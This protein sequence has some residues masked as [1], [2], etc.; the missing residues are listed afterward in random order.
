MM[1]DW[2]ARL[3]DPFVK[4]P[5]QRPPDRM[6][7]FARFFLAPTKGLLAAIIIVSFLSAVAEMALL[8]FLGIVV[9]WATVTPPAEFFSR[10]GWALAGMA[11]VILVVRPATTLLSRGLTSIAFVPGLTALVRWQSYR[12]VLR[13]SLTF[14]QNDFAGRVA[15]KVL[16]SG[17]ALR[18][19]VVN[20]I[21]GI[22][23]LVVY[24][25]GTIALFAGLDP[26]LIIP[27]VLW[28]VAY[29]ATIYFM[30]PPV[31]SKSEVAAEANS[32]LS[33][34]VVDSYT[35]IQT[36]KLFASSSR[37]EAF[38]RDGMQYHTDRFHEM[39]R[40]LSA[41]VIW[42]W[43][44]NGL[45]IGGTAAL[46]VWLWMDGL[47]TVGAL[48]LATG[49]ALRV[50]NMSGWI[51]WTI[52]NIFENVGTVQEGMETIA[53]PH[54]LVDRAE[55]RPIAV[56]EGGIA[57]RDVSF[58][59]GRPGR[60][61]RR[62][63]T[64]SIAPRREGRARSAARARASRRW[65]T[66]CCASTTWKAG[67]DP[68]RRPGHIAEVTQD[69]LRA[70]DRR[71]DAGY[72]AAAPLG[73]RQRPSTAGPR[74][75]RP[76]IASAGRQGAGGQPASPISCRG[77]ADMKGRAGLRRPCRRAR[78]QAVGRPAP[79]DRDRPPPVEGCADPGAG[80]GDQRRSTRRSRRRS[81]SS[82]FEPDGGA[83]R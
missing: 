14:F 65:S 59:Y 45:L 9:D 56:V 42:L 68:G 7:A 36:V 18:E 50:N 62:A 21:E 32:G 74:R 23:T 67:R 82:L 30:V 78:R 53:K 38:A 44:I 57:F 39:L 15:Q 11:F 60:P 72:V 70:A 54:G 75:A 8:V 43:L 13:Q 48:A 41:M 83:R 66:C 76:T 40:P 3:Y 1:F 17:P 79:A 27:V 63:S 4:A 35:N 80:R 81:R 2:F 16:Q 37:E 28:G 47:V 34:R 29:V 73:A 10:Y 19:S 6:L 61:H 46:S 58:H 26:W 12:Y 5:V 24:L 49:L 51:M 31:R 69:S 64:L 77:L 20:I 71:G 33:G 52:T 22:F 25:A 55:A